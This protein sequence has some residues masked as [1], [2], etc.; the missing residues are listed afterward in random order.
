MTQVDQWRLF[1]LDRGLLEHVWSCMF[2][3][4]F[5]I[6]LHTHSTKWGLTHAKSLGDHASLCH[7]LEFSKREVV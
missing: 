3:I 2:A 1:C 5:L 7:F 4:L 6:V